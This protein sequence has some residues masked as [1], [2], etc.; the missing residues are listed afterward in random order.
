MEKQSHLSLSLSHES[1]LLINGLIFFFLARSLPMP[2]VVDISQFLTTYFS[3]KYFSES[4]EP[5]GEPW[6]RLSFIPSLYCKERAK[7]REGGRR[8]RPKKRLVREDYMDV[9]SGVGGIGE[10]NGSAASSGAVPIVSTQ[11]IVLEQK[12]IGETELRKIIAYNDK[13]FDVYYFMNAVEKGWRG[14][15]RDE[16]V[17]ARLWFAIDLDF[18]LPCSIEELCDEFGLKP[19]IVVST[20]NR[21]GVR[22]HQILWGVEYGY[23]KV[24]NAVSGGLSGDLDRVKDLKLLARDVCNCFTSDNISDAKRLLRLPGTQNWKSANPDGSGTSQSQLIYS[25]V[26]SD[27]TGAAICYPVDEF[28]AAVERFAASGLA[29]ELASLGFREKSKGG[30]AAGEKGE[31]GSWVDALDRARAGQWT[32][33]IGARHNALCSWGVQMAASGM[34]WRDVE[35]RI[36][37]L[38]LGAFEEGYTDDDNFEAVVRGVRRKWEE[39]QGETDELIR[40]ADDPG[41]E[42]EIGSRPGTTKM[43]NIFHEQEDP[44]IVEDFTAFSPDHSE[45]NEDENGGEDKGEDL[46][47]VLSEPPEELDP[48]KPWDYA[49]RLAKRCE[50]ESEAHWID[51]LGRVLAAALLFDD[52]RDGSAVPLGRLLWARLAYTG[53]EHFG[54]YSAPVR[55]REPFEY[56]GIE[57]LSTERARI[58]IKDFLH[59]LSVE[60]KRHRQKLAAHRAVLSANAGKKKPR[61]SFASGGSLEVKAVLD[62]LDRQ[63]SG[64]G[65]TLSDEGI[66][67][68]QNG[69]FDLNLWNVVNG[70]DGTIEKKIR[71]CWFPN[72]EKQCAGVRRS[73]SWLRYRHTCAVDFSLEA[74]LLWA[75]NGAVAAPKMDYFLGSAVGGN[76]ADIVGLYRIVGYCLLADNPFQKYFYFEGIAGTGKGTMAEIILAIA[77]KHQSGRV[78]VQ[79]FE[80]DAWLGPLEGK[81]VVLVDEAEDVS[82][83]THKKMLLELAR[84][85]GEPAVASRKLHRDSGEIRSTQKF[86]LTT[87][88]TLET[89]DQ[90]GQQARRIV[91]INFRFKPKGQIVP[92]LWKQIVLGDGSLIATRACLELA[93]GWHFQERLFSA[94][95]EAGEALTLGRERFLETTG[96]LNEF[97]DKIIDRDGP[98]LSSL[99][100]TA[101]CQVWIQETGGRGHLLQQLEVKIK[102]E[103]TKISDWKEKIPHPISEKGLTAGYAARGKGFSG[104]G[105]NMTELLS[106]IGVSEERFIEL[107]SKKVGANSKTW[108]LA[109]G[110]LVLKDSRL[111][112]TYSR[113]DSWERW[114][115]KVNL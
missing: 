13:G 11:E 84:V 27:G 108:Y 37:E 19:S 21:G 86:V 33:G 101:I 46:N 97:L 12:A 50:D 92:N 93:A 57:I 10:A 62:V 79:R 110:L 55:Y 56:W 74:A 99:L 71:R 2:S 52:S 70:S 18:Q 16:N 112:D 34:F 78:A 58:L 7:Q 73:V 23:G 72:S 113:N 69:Y 5:C 102:Q 35:S 40:L 53:C 61:D 66:I 87:N 76:A 64:A 67:S 42:L 107:F 106:E 29:G 54:R 63:G 14:Y 26:A 3:H 109:E 9:R 88:K 85:T 96:G 77:G 4:A 68:F 22:H 8:G 89:D 31:Y 105:I 30:R 48:E 44:E 25:S 47:A 82:P 104:L 45:K 41:N 36:R 75:E 38:R 90:S 81:G 98:G 1:L 115:D 51:Y 114:D 28:S 39:I 83:A 20:S 100:L 94:G 43:H 65:E 95:V 17:V 59:Q 91:P 6:I 103:L 32:A 49:T 24:G 111:W 60:C 80:S 15:A